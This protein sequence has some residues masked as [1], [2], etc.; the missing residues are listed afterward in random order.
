TGEQTPSCDFTRR[1]ILGH[2]TL[3]YHRCDHMMQ[4]D[5][6]PSDSVQQKIKVEVNEG[7]RAWPEE[8]TEDRRRHY[9]ATAGIRST[10]GVRGQGSS[11]AYLRRGD[12]VPVERRQNRGQR[13]ELSLDASDTPAARPSR[14]VRELLNRDHPRA[15]RWSSS[16]FSSSLILTITTGSEP[17][18]SSVTVQRRSHRSR[19]ILK[20]SLATPGSLLAAA[21]WGAVCIP[22]RSPTVQLDPVGETEKC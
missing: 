11:S 9:D 19:Q 13:A 22:V 20:W 16:V 14:R 15:S 3:Q 10:Q 12:Q 7:K 4:V 18:T 6:P 17:I 5:A 2:M 8:K 21:R 1:L